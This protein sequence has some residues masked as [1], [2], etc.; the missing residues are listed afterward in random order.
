MRELRKRWIERRKQKNINDIESSED[1]Q[2]D[3]LSKAKMSRTE[4]QQRIPIQKNKTATAKSILKQG[5]IDKNLLEETTPVHKSKVKLKQ[6]KL[7][8]QTNKIRNSSTNELSLFESKLH[9][10]PGIEQLKTA[11]LTA[12]TPLHANTKNIPL[13]PSLEKNDITIIEARSI[14]KTTNKL[15]DSKNS[16]QSS[17][18]TKT[19]ERHNRLLRS[20]KISK[21]SSK[22]L[23]TNSRLTRSMTKIS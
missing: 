2:E 21:S 10:K 22:V 4:S 3:S 6:T 13:S 23:R 15:N 20:N 16:D 17:D 9:H 12:S 11:K 18:N 5:K 19:K 7:N 8:F 1:N 14:K